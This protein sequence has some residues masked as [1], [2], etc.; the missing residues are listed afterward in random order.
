[1]RAMIEINNFQAYSKK[2]KTLMPIKTFSPYLRKLHIFFLAGSVTK[3]VFTKLQMPAL[4]KTAVATVGIIAFL[5]LSTSL[6]VNFGL[7][8][9]SLTIEAKTIEPTNT[10]EIYRHSLTGDSLLEKHGLQSNPGGWAQLFDGNGQLLTKRSSMEALSANA[11][12][13]FFVTQ[14]ALYLK[15]AHGAIPENVNSK[16]IFSRPLQP[17]WSITICALYLVLVSAAL[18]RFDFRKQ[19][20]WELIHALFLISLFSVLLW[21]SIHAPGGF[22][23]NAFGGG[24]EAF[25]DDDPGGWYLA[26]AHELGRTPAV[27]IGHPG[28]PMQI[29]LWMI[30][31][32]VYLFTDSSFTYSEAIASNI[33]YVQ[34]LSKTMCS[35]A[36]IGASLVLCKITSL[37]FNNRFIGVLASLFFST[38]FFFV[39]YMTRISTEGFATLFFLLTF[40][41]ILMAH[42]RSDNSRMV[43]AFAFFA[44]FFSIFALYSKI[45][46]MG[47]L[48]FFALACLIFTHFRT[49]TIRQLLTM[50]IACLM[51]AFI[52]WLC[53]DPFMDW[54]SFNSQWAPFG[55]VSGEKENIPTWESYYLTALGIMKAVADFLAQLDIE[56]TLP[57]T[58]YK[59]FSFAFGSVAMLLFVSSFFWRSLRKNIIFVAMSLYAALTIVIFLYKGMAHHYL[60]SFLAVASISSAFVIYQITEKTSDGTP[61]RRGLFAFF[62]V[63][64]LNIDGFRV[65]MNSHTHREISN[66]GL[67][68]LPVYTAL[69]RLSPGETLADMHLLSIPKLVG[70]FTQDS[71]NLGPPSKLVEALSQFEI[72]PKTAAAAK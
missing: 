4:K 29:G 56:K 63:F 47:P 10:P 14:S 22:F 44:C 48:P 26:S 41:F 42:Q 68:S 51:G 72:P 46:L 18:F 65:A 34:V 1:M 70:V 49:S 60:F 9:A 24:I 57:I 8:R 50:V 15:I 20:H 36:F 59:H 11:T 3:L 13:G 32:F 37:L 33:F 71:Y 6:F 61:V 5:T 16:Y 25:R 40:L 17:N 23:V 7:Y 67:G 28:I 35:L 53:L 31:K 38:S 66:A 30:Q 21:S 64:L 55:L 52:A 19:D 39:Y 27:F 69:S 45:H 12:Y 2:Q 58:D 43:S 54:P 62:L